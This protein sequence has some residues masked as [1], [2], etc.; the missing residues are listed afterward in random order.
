MQSEIYHSLSTPYFLFSLVLSGCVCYLVYILDEL[1]V[2]ANH[3]MCSQV[4]FLEKYGFPLLYAV[5]VR[6]AALKRTPSVGYTAPA[7]HHHQPRYY[8][9]APSPP[10]SGYEQHHYTCASSG[11]RFL[12]QRKRS[13]M[14]CIKQARTG[15]VCKW[16]TE[17]IAFTARQESY[18]I[19]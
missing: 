18:S 12:T 2:H 9:P 5:T 19:A 14:Q 15:L 11:R 13:D 10:L 7:S 6:P 3:V 17:S 16:V 1:E 4:L 8:F